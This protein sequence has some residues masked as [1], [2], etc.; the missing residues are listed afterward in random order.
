MNI[1][2]VLFARMGAVVSKRALLLCVFVGSWSVNSRAQD[3]K[4]TEILDKIGKKIQTYKTLTISFS[5]QLETYSNK[6]KMSSRKQ[7]VLRLQANRYAVEIGEQRIFCD[8]KTQWIYDKSTNEVQISQPDLSQNKYTISPQKIFADFCSY[9][10]D[11]LYKLNKNQKFGKR[12]YTEIELT[13]LDK[14]KTFFKILLYCSQN[15]ELYRI[16][17]FDKTG[18]RYTYTAHKLVAN[19]PL[20]DDLFRFKKEDYKNVEEVDLR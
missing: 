7:G 9:K 17:V 8:G 11:F 6:I 4:A 19:K 10:K 5:V 1:P 2:F 12:V 13:P 3:P 14:T 18:A 20:R 16:V 15:H